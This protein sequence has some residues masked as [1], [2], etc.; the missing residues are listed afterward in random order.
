MDP[1]RMHHENAAG[2]SSSPTKIAT[3][4]AAQAAK[5]PPVIPSDNRP[6]ANRLPAACLRP[7]KTRGSE[8]PLLAKPPRRLTPPIPPAP[9]GP[10]SPSAPFPPPTTALSKSPDPRPNAPNPPR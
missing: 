8:W 4:P 2:P 1:A 7:T 10:P 5:S 9:L 3:S 6:A